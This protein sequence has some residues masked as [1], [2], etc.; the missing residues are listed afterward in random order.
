MSCECLVNWQKSDWKS[1]EDMNMGMRLLS[2]R[3]VID[4]VNL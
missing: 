4:R 1:A 2:Y 3:Q